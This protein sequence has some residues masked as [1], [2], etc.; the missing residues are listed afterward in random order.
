M[1]KTTLR[2]ISFCTKM[3]E[4]LSNHRIS[5][6][7][8]VPRPQSSLLAFP[9]YLMFSRDDRLLVR[10]IFK[11]Y[12]MHSIFRNFRTLLMYFFFFQVCRAVLFDRKM[13]VQYSKSKTNITIDRKKTNWVQL[14]E[15]VEREIQPTSDYGIP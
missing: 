13:T 4:I 10:H 14:I 7:V 3:F 12:F 8:V 15:I 5:A 6:E 9:K 2:N 1:L 11:Y